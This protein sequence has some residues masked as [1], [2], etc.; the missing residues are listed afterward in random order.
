MAAW[1]VTDEVPDAGMGP[2]GKGGSILYEYTVSTSSHPFQP[3]LKRYW[4]LPA[5]LASYM[6]MSAARSRSVGL[7]PDPAR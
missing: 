5:R 2:A 3:G 6:A 1:A 4:F 7:V